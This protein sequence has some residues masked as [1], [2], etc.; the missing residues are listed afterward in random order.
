MCWTPATDE[1]IAPA[2]SASRDGALSVVLF[3]SFI[4]HPFF[5]MVLDWPR[6]FLCLVGDI[7]GIGV[8]D[9]LLV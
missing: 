6:L 7:S 5:V 2:R 9:N 3:F 1:L 8:S 4:L